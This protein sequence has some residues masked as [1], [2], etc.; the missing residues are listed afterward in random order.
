MAFRDVTRRNILQTG[1]AAGVATLLP[2][3]LKP[4]AAVDIGDSVLSSVS[5]GNLVLP[6]SFSYPDAP[7]DDLVRLLQANGLPTDTLMPD[8]NVPVLKTSERLILFDVGSGQNFMPSAGR[9]LDNMADAGFD[10][11]EVTD[12]VF[13]HCHPDHLW[14]LIDDFDEMIFANADYH[15]GRAEWDFWRDPATVD[16]MPEERKTFAVGAANRLVHLE[17]RIRLFE[18]GAEVLPGIEAVD[19]AGHTPGHMSFLLHGGSNPVFI[20]GDALTHFAVS[21]EQP[22]WPSGSDQDPVKG[23]ETRLRL[24]DRLVADNAVLAGYHL[25]SPGEGRV[26]RKG[27]AYRFVAET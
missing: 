16:A 24:L 3:G 14:G 26:E 17:D 5:D 13:T 27:N 9:L 18:A 7:A 1:L 11:A 15:M 4:A 10:P 2:A 12:V 23:A 8:C 22:G 25:P 21:F 19:T 20:G 6:V